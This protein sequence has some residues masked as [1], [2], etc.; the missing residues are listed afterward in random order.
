MS[1]RRLIAIV[2]AVGLVLA[3]AGA[4][5]VVQL[6]TQASASSKPAPE[7]PM[8][9][10]ELARA[11]EAIASGGGAAPGRILTAEL[12]QAVSVYMSLG[13]DESISSTEIDPALI[14]ATDAL[15]SIDSPGQADY[16]AYAAMTRD[17]ASVPNI[18][19]AQRIASDFAKALEVDGGICA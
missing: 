7:E 11:E 10:E 19:D 17:P 6:T 18:S 15:A 5:V 13:S 2:V 9:E 8:A 16:Q 12:C 14:A 3:A 1:K 4:I